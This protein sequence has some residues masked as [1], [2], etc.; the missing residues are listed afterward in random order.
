MRKDLNNLHK[1]LLKM[2][3]SFIDNGSK[4]SFFS[5]NKNF[6]QIENENYLELCR[7]T[8]HF[9]PQINCSKIIYTIANMIK[10]RHLDLNNSELEKISTIAEAYYYIGLKIQLNVPKKITLSDTNEE[11]IINELKYMITLMLKFINV[12]LKLRHLPSAIF[13]HNIYKNGFNVIFHRNI[14]ISI[15]QVNF[16]SFYP[17]TP[18]IMTT[19]YNT[20]VTLIS[21]NKGLSLYYLKIKNEIAREQEEKK[22]PPSLCIIL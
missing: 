5:V 9:T 6:K 17:N 19:S 22:P 16:N 3:E 18:A 11:I 13:L 20:P 8:F 21:R 15:P 1:P 10:T 2:I 14:E 4:K 7:L 12:S